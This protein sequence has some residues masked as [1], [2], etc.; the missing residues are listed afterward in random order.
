MLIGIDRIFLSVRVL[1]IA[2]IPLPFSQG[3]PKTPTTLFNII[4]V[5]GQHYYARIALYPRFVA[6]IVVNM[7][8]FVSFGVC[9]VV[10]CVEGKTI[11][12]T[13]GVLPTTKN[14]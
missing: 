10:V 4:T 12:V 8:V 9:F 13:F 11:Y 3:K 2:I 1:Y 7:H 14:Q 5:I 6:V